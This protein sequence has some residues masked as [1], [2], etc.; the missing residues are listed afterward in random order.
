MAN[1]SELRCS[2]SGCGEIILYL[3]AA[4][5]QIV[6]C[7]KCGEMSRLPPSPSGPGSPP[8]GSPSE[9]DQLPPKAC[10]DCGSALKPTDLACSVCERRR[11]RTRAALVWSA[12]AVV[13]VFVVVSVLVLVRHRARPATPDLPQA[14]Q[15]Q[16]AVKTPKSLDDLKIG[17]FVL[18]R[19]RGSDPGLV[20]GDI[21]N[22]SGNLHRD[23]RV[24]LELLDAQGVKLEVLSDF[25]TELPAHATWHVIANTSNSKAVNVRVVGLKEPP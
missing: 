17:A 22:L 15:T 1:S 2:C 13:S 10:P 18:E 6:E 12:T 24:N 16:P 25:I 4:V 21:Q 19:R 9:P 7:P 8:A 20:V 14:I 5:G 3:P 23:V 11:R